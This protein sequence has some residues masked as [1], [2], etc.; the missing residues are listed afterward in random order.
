MISLSADLSVRY[1]EIF[2]KTE[3]DKINP[4]KIRADS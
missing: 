2:S 1:A 4:Q 3:L